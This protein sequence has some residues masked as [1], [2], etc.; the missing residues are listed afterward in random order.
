MLS[1]AKAI[2]PFVD[3][4]LASANAARLSADKTAEFRHLERA[5]VLGQAS[6]VQHVRAHWRMLVW[7]VRQ[8]DQKELFGQLLRIFGAATKTFV[9]LVPEGNTGGANVSPVLP[10]PIP[11]DLAAIIQRARSGARDQPND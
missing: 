1:Y 10:L 9:G 6:T 3:A 4:E 11:P 7:S 5:H 8:G 2:R